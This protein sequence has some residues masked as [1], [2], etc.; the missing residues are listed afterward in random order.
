[1]TREEPIP[2]TKYVVAVAVA[3]ALQCITD[4]LGA[5]TSWD[6]YM[7]EAYAALSAIEAAGLV[8]VPRDDETREVSDS[9]LPFDMIDAGI[10]VLEGVHADHQNYVAGITPDWDDGMVAVAVYRAMTAAAAKG[11]E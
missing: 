5:R 11:G 10:T 9:A 4:P 7:P 6:D 2:T 3:K 1:M 8:C